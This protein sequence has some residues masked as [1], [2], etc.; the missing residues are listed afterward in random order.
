MWSSDQKH[1]SPHTASQIS[2]YNISIRHEF[3][4]VFIVSKEILALA[5]RFLW[6]Y[7]FMGKKIVFIR[8][9]ESS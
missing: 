4:P 9:F 3:E 1:L 5:F 8:D 6:I 7:T 2:D